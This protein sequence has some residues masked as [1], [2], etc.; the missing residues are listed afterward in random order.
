MKSFLPSSN[1]GQL[2]YSRNMRSGKSHF[3]LLCMLYR[4]LLACEQLDFW[5]NTNWYITKTNPPV[6]LDLSLIS[7]MD[8][9]IEDLWM[10]YCVTSTLVQLPYWKLKQLASMILTKPYIRILPKPLATRLF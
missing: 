9:G 7:Q 5:K 10:L 6:N 3:G 1:N 8:L 2:I 4:N